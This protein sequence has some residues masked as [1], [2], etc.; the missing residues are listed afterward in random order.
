MSPRHGVVL[1]AIAGSGASQRRGPGCSADGVAAAENAPRPDID[2][3]VDGMAP[4][5]TRAP[6]HSIRKKNQ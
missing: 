1:C 3:L 6:R 4:L 2:E 5:I